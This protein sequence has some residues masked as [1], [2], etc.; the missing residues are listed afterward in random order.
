MP[1]FSSMVL[2]IPAQ[3][4]S[5]QAAEEMA[6]L[7]YNRALKLSRAGD[8]ISS[9]IPILSVKVV[10]NSVKLGLHLLVFNNL[11]CSLLISL[12]F[13]IPKGFDYLLLP[14]LCM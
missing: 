1:A 5:D 2:Q 6:L 9:V 11:C 7:A 3:F 4:C 13:Y 10:L 8:R 12:A 14:L